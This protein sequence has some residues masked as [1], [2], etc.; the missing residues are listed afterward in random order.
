MG[1]PF[2]EGSAQKWGAR[3]GVYF[4]FELEQFE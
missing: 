3:F 1:I 2:F 4:V